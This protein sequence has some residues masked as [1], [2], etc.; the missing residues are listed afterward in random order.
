MS[1]PGLRGGGALEEEG[2]AGRAAS[3]NRKEWL[4]T[5]SV[6]NPRE[7]AEDRGSGV[8]DIGLSS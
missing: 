6:S 2:G 8:M 1:R 3:Q 5:S 4:N 7:R